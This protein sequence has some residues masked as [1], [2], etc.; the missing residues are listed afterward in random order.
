[1]ARIE[2]FANNASTNLSSAIN[3]AVTSITVDDASPFP[4]DGD[5]RIII[6]SEL[7][8]V[9]AV[10]GTIFTVIRG[11]EGSTA[12]SHNSAVIIVHIATAAGMQQ[13]NIQNGVPMFGN[14]AR[15]PGTFRDKAGN[16]LALASFTA[17]NLGTS[18]AWDYTGGQG[19]GFHIQANATNS[20]RVWYKSAPTPPW[21]LT[22]WCGITG[23]AGSQIFVGCKESGP[24]GSLSLAVTR[25]TDVAHDDWTSPT[26][27]S[28]SQGVNGFQGQPLGMWFQVEDDNVNLY[29]RC[30]HDGVFWA[31]FHQEAR[32]NFL[33]S[34]D[35]LCFG[36]NDNANELGVFGQLWAWIEE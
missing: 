16:E 30:S 36:G 10:S 12:T 14:T 34:V 5:F 27:Y 25:I 33:S 2:R 9:T 24:T 7:M 18:S 6:D 4:T 3:A 8:L 21:T 32:L 26:V 29:F 11:I 17:A 31:T 22:V 19:I 28:A 35:E 20:A 23:K 1:M 15:K 13:Y